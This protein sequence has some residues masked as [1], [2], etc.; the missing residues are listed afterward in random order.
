MA[1]DDKTDIESLT[2]EEERDRLIRRIV[3]RDI[4]NHQSLYD[5]LEQE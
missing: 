5:E 3:R 4:E 1:T 2:P